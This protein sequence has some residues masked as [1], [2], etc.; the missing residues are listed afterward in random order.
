MTE[1][2][3]GNDLYISTERA[4]L[5]S[6]S[7]LFFSRAV[8]LLFYRKK[9]VFQKELFL[10]LFKFIL[11]YSQRCHICMW[12]SELWDCFL[13]SSKVL[14]PEVR[15]S[16]QDHVS[17]PTEPTWWPTTAISQ[18]TSY[19]FIIYFCLSLFHFLCISFDFY[20]FGN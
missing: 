5:Y 11:I 7:V 8:L 19:V 15:S 13:S 2:Q 20:Y 3:D 1:G 12:R 10:S 16:V 14:G 6:D 9:L 18:L 4:T 17:L